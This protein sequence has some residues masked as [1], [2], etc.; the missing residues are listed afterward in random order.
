MKHPETVPELLNNKEAADYLG[1]SPSTLNNS[2]YIGTLGRVTA[3]RF[4]KLG[5]TIRYQRADLDNWL[6]QFTPQT[7]TSQSAR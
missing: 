4:R 2:R 1:F 7:N 3:P 5:K 6:E